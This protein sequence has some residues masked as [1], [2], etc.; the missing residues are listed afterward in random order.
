MRI[1]VNVFTLSRKL[2]GSELTMLNFHYEF[3][4]ELAIKNRS[5]ITGDSSDSKIGR[6]VVHLMNMDHFYDVDSSN[7]RYSVSKAYITYFEF[8]N[9]SLWSSRDNLIKSSNFR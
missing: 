5:D 7:S 3:K 2:D 6:L 9:N 4:F 1:R 8:E